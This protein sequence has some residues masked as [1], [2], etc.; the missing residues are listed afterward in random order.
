MSNKVQGER[1]FG[2][3]SLH[4]LEGE[5]LNPYQEVGS[6]ESLLHMYSGPIT[7]AI[8]LDVVLCITSSRFAQVTDTQETL[9][10]DY[11]PI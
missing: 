8:H 9:W 3:K 1:S 4:D 7:L 10:C 2:G 11:T 5:G 6:C